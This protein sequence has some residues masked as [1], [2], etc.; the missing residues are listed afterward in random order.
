MENVNDGALIQRMASGDTQ[1]VAL[2][3]DRFGRRAYSLAFRIVRDRRWAEDVVQ[4]AFVSAWRMAGAYDARRGAASTWLLAIVH[5]RAIDVYRQIRSR[6]PVF[7]QPGLE[8]D[9]A[10]DVFDE[11]ARLVDGE[12]VRCAVD[13]LPADQRAAIMHAYFDGLTHH[14]IAERT[15]L[16]L[17]TV[18]SRIRLGM[19]KL[20]ELLDRD[21]VAR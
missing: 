3:Y 14:E 20:R 17:G 8:A 6:P 16:P 15:G 1:A 2:L 18:K 19:E 13:R 9:Q 5:H 12:Y 11:A 4:E 7:E 10:P 21:R